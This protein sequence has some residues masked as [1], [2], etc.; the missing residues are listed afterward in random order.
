MLIW[1]IAIVITVAILKLVKLE[2]KPA[3][4]AI[5]SLV[6]RTVLV[7]ISIP[8]AGLLGQTDRVVNLSNISSILV[9]LGL[10]AWSFIAKSKLCMVGICIYFL[11]G[12]IGTIIMLPSLPPAFWLGTGAS[13]AV[14]VVG[15]VSGIYCLS[16][17]STSFPKKV[18]VLTVFE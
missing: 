12:V 11:F 10:S 7:L 9:A 17:W 2:T 4:L 15:L 1:L 5:G 18:E 16:T 3:K 14:A 8:L 6:L 13:A